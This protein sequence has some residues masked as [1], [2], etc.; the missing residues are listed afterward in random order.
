MNNT[1]IFILC[2]GEGKRLGNL[3]KKTPKPLIRVNGKYILDYK[4]EY[5]KSIK[6]NEY[7]FCV[8]HQADKII[9]YAKNIKGQVHISDSGTNAGILKRIYEARML[10][11][12]ATIIGYGDTFAQLNFNELLKSHQCSDFD[13]TLVIAPIVN[14]F[15]LVKWDS[16]G[17][18]TSFDEKP[19]L[20][21]FIGYMIFNRKIFDY[22]PIEFINLPDGVGIVKLINYMLTLKKVGIYK[23]DGLKFTVNTKT[24]LAEANQLVSQYFTE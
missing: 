11:S 18:V 13:L 1:R 22:I 17:C 7:V 15:G 9:N 6:L 19:L 24:E 10:M 14:P 5:Y 8:G 23:F 21:H 2:G 3:T 16:D 20:N 4:I 12:D